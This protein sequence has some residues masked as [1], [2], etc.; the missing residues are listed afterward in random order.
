MTRATGLPEPAHKSR[1]CSPKSTP[2]SLVKSR[3]FFDARIHD[4]RSAPGHISCFRSQEK[5]QFMLASHCSGTKSG[6][7]EDKG[8]IFTLMS[9]WRPPLHPTSGGGTREKNQA[10]LSHSNM[11]LVKFT[12]FTGLLILFRTQTYAFLFFQTSSLTPTIFH[13]ALEL[14]RTEAFNLRHN[15]TCS[16]LPPKC[17]QI[18]VSHIRLITKATRRASVRSNASVCIAHLG[19]P[20]R[21][22]VQ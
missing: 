8:V 5:P 7:T 22:H 2:R 18:K 21:T 20:V 6:G 17:L 19:P 4:E 9:V 14:E 12:V 3:S 15:S 11:V 1:L 13:D 16:Y 10:R